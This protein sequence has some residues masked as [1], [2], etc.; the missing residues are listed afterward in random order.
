MPGIVGRPKKE[1]ET[2][3]QQLG[4]EARK[5]IGNKKWQKRVRRAIDTLRTLVNFDH[6]YVGGGNAKHL[7]GDLPA[8]VSL[9]DNSAGILGGIRLWDKA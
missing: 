2:Y 7:E 1:G 6:L 9:V 5:A 8:D 3:D 4:N